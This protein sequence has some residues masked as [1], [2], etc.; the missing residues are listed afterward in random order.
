[1]ALNEIRF[2]KFAKITYL[3]MRLGSLGPTMLRVG[4]ILMTEY[5]TWPQKSLAVSAK[6]PQISF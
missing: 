1:M 2:Q 3:E 4:L 5:F 6:I